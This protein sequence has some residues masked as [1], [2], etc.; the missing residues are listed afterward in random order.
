MTIRHNDL[1][2]VLTI[3]LLLVAILLTGCG[4]RI[5]TP[6]YWITIT[7]PAT[8]P[9][10]ATLMTYTLAAG[11][12]S[13][14]NKLEGM[15]QA[16]LVI[17]PSA[18]VPAA[19]R[20]RLMAFLENEELRPDPNNRGHVRV[21]V[22]LVNPDLWATHKTYTGT[23]KLRGG[24][25]GTVS[26]TIYDT[27]REKEVIIGSG[28][29]LLPS[30]Y[31]FG[32]VMGI[33][34]TELRPTL[35]AR[36]GYGSKPEIESAWINDRSQLYNAL[37][38]QALDEAVTAALSSLQRAWRG[39]STRV[40][41]HFARS[42]SDD[43]RWVQAWADL[44]RMW[45]SLGDVSDPK[46]FQHPDIAAA[47]RALTTVA[48]NPALGEFQKEDAAAAN[49]NL[50]VIAALK[51]DYSGASSFADHAQRGDPSQ[52]VY[53]TMPNLIGLFHRARG[54]KPV[55]PVTP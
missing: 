15:A 28:W 34:D 21:V 40:D 55:S 54:T 29:G 8:N 36:L 3:S 37:M 10:P 31:G 32:A 42:S 47:E 45:D 26:V 25:G 9:K 33:N 44:N 18:L 17:S 27:T 20:Q 35:S 2:A 6:P 12:V 23:L 1:R 14:P 46:R 50:G 49:W 24:S 48:S 7:A 51:S 22:S 39:G 19:Q 38:N 16:P 5:S 41:L 52:A 43:P 53:R 4:P 11:S 13:V 30:S